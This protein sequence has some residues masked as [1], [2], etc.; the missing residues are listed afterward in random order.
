[1]KTHQNA[2][3]LSFNCAALLPTHPQPE[4]EE[5]DE[6]EDARFLMLAALLLPLRA[7]MVSGPKGKPARA[8]DVIIR[9]SIKWRNSDVTMTAQLHEMVRANLLVHMTVLHL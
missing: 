4:K 5:K 2:E 8:T 9:E 3:N 7:C 6:K 1:M